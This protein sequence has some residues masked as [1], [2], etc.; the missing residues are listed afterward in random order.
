MYGLMV[1]IDLSDLRES[2]RRLFRKK[3]NQLMKR[4]NFHRIKNAVYFI[5]FKKFVPSGKE[6]EDFEQ[7][8]SLIRKFHV[9]ALYFMISLVKPGY[10]V[11][12]NPWKDGR[13]DVSR[14]K[15]FFVLE[16]IK[17]EEE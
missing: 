13:F 10:L 15:N 8:W 4:T 6:V 14:M 3:R 2:G 1:I 7:F 5:P 16:R 17:I 12:G 11:E 9:K